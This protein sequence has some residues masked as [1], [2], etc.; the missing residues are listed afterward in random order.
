M[1]LINVSEGAFLAL[2]GLALIAKNQPL[3]VNAKVLARELN[4]SSAHLSKVFQ[5]LGKAGLVNSVRGPAGGFELNRIPEKISFLEIYEIIE[6]KVVLEK[7]SL[8]KINCAFN[9]CIFNGKLNKISTDIY[10]TFKNINL[11]DFY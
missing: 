2:H 7:C 6:G 9:S 11:S 8:N 4:A 1:S 5:K 10:K 3:R